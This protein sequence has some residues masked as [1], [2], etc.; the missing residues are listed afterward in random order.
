MSSKPLNYKIYA[1]GFIILLFS[2]FYFQILKGD[3]YLK[4]AKNNYVRLIPITSIR[5]VIF[6]SNSRVLAYDKPFFN[7]AVVPYHIRDNRDELFVS[8]AEYL[9]I[10]P[11]IIYRNYKKN[12]LNYFS[13]VNIVVDIPKNKALA[14]TEKFS[15]ILINPEPRRFYPYPYSMSH[16]LGYVK[17]ASTFYDKLKKYGYRPLERVGFN[18]IE[19]YYDSYLRGQDG[20]DLIEVNAHG[21][22]VGFLGRRSPRK[23]K[24]IYLTID[25]QA[26]EIAYDALENRKGSIILIE[27]VSGRVK[28]MVSSPAYDSN[29]MISGKGISKF[30]NDN[31]NTPML[32]RS[33]KGLYPIGS[34]FKPIE[35]LAGLEERTIRTNT[36]FLCEGAFNLGAARFRCTH[37]HGRQDIYQAI[38]HSCNIYFYNLALLMGP[39]I[40]SGWAEKFALSSFTGIDLPGEKKGVVPSPAWKQKRYHDNWYSG[41]TL[42]LSIG[43]GYF[44]S[45]PLEILVAT[46]VFASGGYIVRPYLLDRVDTESYGV[47]SQKKIAVTEENLKIVV[48]AMRQAVSLDTGTARILNSLDLKI[49]GKTGTA[50][51]NGKSHG[52]FVGF[53]PYDNP[54][55]SFCV[56]LE[57]GGSSYEALKIAKIFL[58]KLKDEGLL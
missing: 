40:L 52:W 33:I 2:F 34:T 51:A 43:Q 17:E 11:K 54:K 14:L 56:F 26:Q 7:L 39:E 58:M 35:A 30:L 57:H 38:A 12:L 3:E 20:G 28:A 6:D 36:S 19:Q 16:I 21:N 1:T 31:E 24:D 55:Y 48:E 44:V 42:N 53:F 47:K 18:G 45:T 22:S 25:A 13:P 49:A 50:Q 4:R 41:D 9:S 10:D 15:D 37:V 46:N 8:L 27:S 23:G 29:K 32:D 5:G